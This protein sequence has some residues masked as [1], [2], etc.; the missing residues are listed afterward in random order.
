[1]RGSTSTDVLTAAI[2][3]RDDVETQRWARVCM[4][5]CEHHA[6]RV[7]SVVVDA[8]Q[9]GA[10]WMSVVRMMADGVVQVCVVPRWDHMPPDRLPRVEVIAEDVA[11]DVGAPERPRIIGL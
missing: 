1:M 2:Y 11:R 4:D 5:W 8:T 7:V 10:K 9:D 6:Y 3:L